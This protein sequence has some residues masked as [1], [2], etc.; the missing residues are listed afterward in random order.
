M[1]TSRLMWRGVKDSAAW[2]D[3]RNQSLAEKNDDDE[4]ER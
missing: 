2:Q 3:K 1:G 4:K